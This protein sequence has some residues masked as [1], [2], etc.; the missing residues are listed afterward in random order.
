M[1]SPADSVMNEAEEISLADV[2]RFLLS[3][4]K[5]IVACGTAGV[6]G[7]WFYLNGIPA[8]YEAQTIVAM[9][10]VPVISI[11]EES[12]M[13][14]NK[15]EA[16]ELPTLLAE[17]MSLSSTLPESTIHACGLV[18]SAELME[19]LK[20]I[21]SNNQHSTLK[22]SVRHSS[23]KL[24]KR[25]ANAVFEMIREQQAMLVKPVMARL[26]NSLDAFA[27]SANEMGLAAKLAGSSERDSDAIR[28]RLAVRQFRQ[29]LT[30]D[31]GTRM[32]AP[33]YAPE[34]PVSTSRK[35]VLLSWGAAGVFLGLAV[36]L[37]WTLVVR[38]RSVAA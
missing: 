36:A 10:K 6:L 14:S 32:L 2:I 27:Q 30:A 19:A 5:L 25:C 15:F 18:D 38:F 26:E 11:D 22:F 3:W 29:A 20:I 13:L 28:M 31:T 23:P 33:V 12:L 34:K 9:A 37:L 7:A 24:A 17:R 21:S 16:I 8:T 35:Q 4:W 1:P